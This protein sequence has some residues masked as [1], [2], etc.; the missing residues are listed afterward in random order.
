M[1]GVNLKMGS[2]A[3]QT[4]FFVVDV[5][6]SYYVLLRRDWIHSNN[7]IPL[8]LHQILLLLNESMF[9][10]IHVDNKPFIT[11]ANH[12]ETQF[13]TGKWSTIRITQ[14]SSSMKIKEIEDEICEILTMPLL[15]K[16]P[17]MKMKISPNE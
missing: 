2:L 1:I 5:V 13:N 8:T 4:I 11:C 9:E 12:L 6:L 10:V 15:T 17:G 3:T 7:C 16:E 14:P